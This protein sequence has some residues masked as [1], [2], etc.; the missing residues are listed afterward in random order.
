MGGQQAEGGGEA[1]GP[2]LVGQVAVALKGL[3]RFMRSLSQ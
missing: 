1:Q 3:N 2:G